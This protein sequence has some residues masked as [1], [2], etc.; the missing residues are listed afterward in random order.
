MPTK[1]LE[2]GAFVPLFDHRYF[3]E[4]LPCG[5][6]VQKGIAEL[7]GVPT[8]MIDQVIRW[9]QE[10]CGKEYFMENGKVCG[11]D[12]ATTKTPQRYGYVDL[13]TFIR[14]NGYA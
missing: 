4:D 5:I 9:C 3:N 10:R 6:L 12:L 7:A 14:D 2:T 13:D 8:P 1:H 11:K